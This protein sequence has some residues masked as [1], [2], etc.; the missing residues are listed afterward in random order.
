VGS[1]L[2]LV[3]MVFYLNA[4]YNQNEVAKGEWVKDVIDGS[5]STY[6]NTDL[7]GLDFF[8][9]AKLDREIAQGKLK[10]T[11]ED[12]L[13]SSHMTSEME[14]TISQKLDQL[15]QIAEAETKIETLIKER[16]YQDV[17]VAIGEDGSLDMVVNTPSLTQAE[18]VQIADIASRHGNVPIPNIHI[19]NK[20]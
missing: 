10:G 16:G 18:V 15:V 9:K 12:I 14:K 3:A 1:I 4:S 11:I 2:A 20:F 7:D 13:A 8:S 19:K 6:V 17:F 5:G